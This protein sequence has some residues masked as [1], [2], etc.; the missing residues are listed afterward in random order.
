LQV[1]LS[2]FFSPSLLLTKES[3]HSDSPKNRAS[4]AMAV[5]SPTF[6]LTI[7][8]NNALFE[9]W[10][11]KYCKVDKVQASDRLGRW[12]ALTTSTY[13][14]SFDVILLQEFPFKDADWVGPL[15]AAGYSLLPGTLNP[16]EQDASAIAFRAD[17][18][19]LAGAGV[20]CVCTFSDLEKLKDSKNVAFLDY[21]DGYTAV[22]AH[23][24]TIDGAQSF[25]CVSAHV[26]WAETPLERKTL[27]ET[28]LDFATLGLDGND[29]PLLVGGDFNVDA[30]TPWPGGGDGANPG[31]S[32][33]FPARV[34]SPSK[35][36]W[37]L[38]TGI[39]WTH[40]GERGPSQLDYLFVRW[41]SALGAPPS[42]PLTLS[43]K[44]FEVNGVQGQE[45]TLSPRLTST[46]Y[47]SNPLDLILHGAVLPSM[48]KAFMSRG[49]YTQCRF[50]SDH[51][52]VS[53]TITLGT[54]SESA[55]QTEGK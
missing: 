38:S 31:N 13:F 11:Q 15:H 37:E 48:H 26:Q 27:L 30:L 45:L 2:F 3:T 5:V 20:Q 55:P 8:A 47:P 39:R 19:Q 53:S 34:F 10:Y 25:Y 49:G 7:A 43:T 16:H 1:P 9:T 44:E 18:F 40:Y 35:G 33:S 28:T 12:V 42:V 23:L 36:W 24:Q 4:K 21:G 54:E 29:G 32:L 51:A 41:P 50:H 52:I 14:R 46:V 6:R 22:R 17:R